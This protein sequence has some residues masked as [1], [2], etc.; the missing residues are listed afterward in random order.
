MQC[1]LN[2]IVEHDVLFGQFQQHGVVKEL[3]DGN[4]FTEALWGRRGEGRGATIKL[5]TQKD[6][7][8]VDPT[9][10]RRAWCVQARNKSAA[11]IHVCMLCILIHSTTSHTIARHVSLACYTLPTQ[12]PGHLRM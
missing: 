11:C 5:E 9:Q 2:G 7:L 8:L 4:V 12:G 1:T 3:V 10:K 6:R